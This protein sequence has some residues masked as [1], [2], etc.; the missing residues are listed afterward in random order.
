MG[1]GRAWSWVANRSTMYQPHAVHTANRRRWEEPCP[2]REKQR[3]FQKQCSYWWSC[4][5]SPR[6]KLWSGTRS[7]RP[8]IKKLFPCAVPPH[9][10]RADGTTP[11]VFQSHQS[12]E[13]QPVPIFF[14]PCGLLTATRRGPEHESKGHC[15]DNAPVES[16][17]SSLKNE[18]V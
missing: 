17:F 16:V 8:L 14:P 1:T 10:G 13:I 3:V 9:R 7:A 18:L 5:V 4:A 15:Y 12:S 11:L 2:P 6:S